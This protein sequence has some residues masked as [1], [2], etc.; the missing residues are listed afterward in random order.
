MK[1]LDL[2][3]TKSVELDTL[4]SK[5]DLYL[6]VGISVSP[7]GGDNPDSIFF[8]VKGY[9]DKASFDA[10]GSKVNIKAFKG[11]GTKG[12]LRGVIK[13]TDINFAVEVVN[14]KTEIT[15]AVVT[16]CKPLIIA[17]IAEKVEGLESE[18]VDWS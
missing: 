13:A 7:G 9:I 12:A 1:Q 15:D 10:G 17:K 14:Y 3:L 6:N 8:T 16:E 4:E 18:I 11:G 5:S 2:K